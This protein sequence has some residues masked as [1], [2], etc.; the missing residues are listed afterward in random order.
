MPFN[1]KSCQPLYK[2]L[3]FIQK[4]KELHTI[5]IC[6]KERGEVKKMKGKILTKQN[7]REFLKPAKFASLRIPRD[8]SSIAF[9]GFKSERLMNQAM[10]KDN[11]FL[12]MLIC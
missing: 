5:S 12:G 7:I 4:W 8:N 2:T 10:R 1:K 6:V 9:V 11:S 3:I